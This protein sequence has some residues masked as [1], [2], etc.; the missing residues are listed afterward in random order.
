MRLHE[1]LAGISL[2]EVE[3]NPNAEIR[4]IAY[5]SLKVRPGDLFAAITGH[6]T[7][8]N[9]FV[10]QALE[11]GAAAVLSERPKPEDVSRPWV[12]V[13]DARQA[14]ALCA[15]NLFGHPS[16]RL[17]VIGITGTK[18]K[19]TVTYILESILRAAGFLPGVFGT[20]NYRGPGIEPSSGRTTPESSDLQAMM[21]TILD[22][23]GTHCILEVSSH[24]LELERVAGIAFN[25]AVFTNL[26]GEHMDYHPT[27]EHYFEAKKKLFLPGLKNVMAVI[28]QDDAWGEKLRSE[29]RIGSITYGLKPGAM[30]RAEKTVLHENGVD[31]LVKYPAGTVNIHSPLIGKPNAYNTLAALATA[32]MLNIPMPKILEGIELCKGVPGRFEKIENSRGLK[33]F[34]DYAHTDNALKNLLETARALEHERIIVVFGAGGDRDTTKRA[35]MGEAAGL[36]SDWAIITSDNPRSEDPMAIIAM[37]E[38][39]V[40]AAGSSRYE[41]IPDRR[42]A[43]RKALNMGRQGDIIL[44]AGKGHEDYQILGPEVI[45]FDDREVVRE[46]LGERE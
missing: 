25:A 41:I 45:H 42:E 12:Q 9:R 2:K 17:S 5:S 21:R 32:L 35:R 29:I 37:V 4:G 44:I 40:K 22:N 38:E 31:L 7:D 28:N 34:V 8:G 13:S 20:I 10:P 26:S 23:G 18:G 19:T 11:K 39:G 15:D 6:I 36:I 33:I 1:V 27:M 3:G 43:I 46:I 14:L 30:V 16:S 24:A